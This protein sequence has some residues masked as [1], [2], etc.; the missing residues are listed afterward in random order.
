MK[1]KEKKKVDLQVLI[2]TLIIV[3]LFSAVVGALG[4]SLYRMNYVK[5]YLRQCGVNLTGNVNV[6][7]QV[8]DTCYQLTRDN[9][10]HMARV[11]VVGT[12]NLERAK[13]VENGNKII[14]T[15][16][17]KDK[18]HVRRVATIEELENTKTKVTIENENGKV[19]VVLD[20]VRYMSLLQIITKDAG[21]D[22]NLII[23]AVPSDK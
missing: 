8:D 6:Y 13:D 12:V 9:A 7:A 3:V 18:E 1:K 16:I 11:L 20:E 21:E 14:L 2:I 15:S 4:F 19:T 23:E 10:N 5:R 22:G 17:S